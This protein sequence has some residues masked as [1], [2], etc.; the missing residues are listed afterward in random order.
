MVY[1][2]SGAPAADV[3]ARKKLQWRWG[4]PGD[5]Q[6]PGEPVGDRLVEFQRNWEAVI[7][8][9]SLRWGKGVAG[10]WVDGCYFADQMYRFDDEPNFA[11]FARALR[12]G[13][14]DAIVAF[15]P[16]VLVP[17]VAHT[18]FEDYSAGEIDHDHLPQAVATCRGRWLEREG[19]PVQFHILT[20]LG[21]TWCGGERPEWPDDKIIGYTRHVV[22]KG[23]AITFDVPIERS[24]L[25]RRPFVD[26]LRA[27]GRSL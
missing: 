19:V 15:N 26:Q 24:G 4:Q 21:K 14:S 11:S 13:N 20:F 6:L 17:V 10:W 8:D 7:R 16:G 12:A 3:V 9:W 18:R 22:E 2:P 5:W 25:I 27:I 1:L 23:G